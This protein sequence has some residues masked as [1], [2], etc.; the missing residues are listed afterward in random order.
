MYRV[1]DSN[2]EKAILQ[3]K[4]QSNNKDESFQHNYNAEV[5]KKGEGK[6]GKYTCSYCKGIGHNARSCEQKKCNILV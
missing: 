4:Q 6:E 2:H 3:P 5:Q 1:N